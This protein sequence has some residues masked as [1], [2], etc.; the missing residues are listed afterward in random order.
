MAFEDRYGLPISTS[1]EAAA[2]AYR[3]GIELMLSSWPG[4]AQALDLAI[5]ADADF[6][7]PYAARARVGSPG[8]ELE[9]AL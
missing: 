8:T 5:G 3:H 2:E 9:F 1:S 6:A 4:A 7:L